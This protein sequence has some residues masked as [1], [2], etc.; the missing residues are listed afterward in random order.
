MRLCGSVPKQP[1]DGR[2][3]RGGHEEAD[4][5]LEGESDHRAVVSSTRSSIRRFRCRAAR[6]TPVA[7]GLLAP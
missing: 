1:A 5:H 7:S 4:D 6:E 2:T 3:D